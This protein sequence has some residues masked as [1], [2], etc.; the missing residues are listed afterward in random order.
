[1][2]TDKEINQLLDRV[3]HNDINGVER[4]LEAGADIDYVTKKVYSPLMV[5]VLQGFPKM[6]KF[7][8]EKG[9]DMD[10]VGPEYETAMDMAKKMY[11][12]MR[13]H[14]NVAEIVAY[15]DIYGMLRD[16]GA[17]TARQLGVVYT[18]SGKLIEQREEAF[19]RALCAVARTGKKARLNDFI[20]K[21]MGGVVDLV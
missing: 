16:K 17:K 6:T 1:M 11:E 15:R 8:L 7:L 21:Q 19:L 5:A 12:H 4:M 13:R 3:V 18:D 9:A 20:E 14:G 10:L 2:I